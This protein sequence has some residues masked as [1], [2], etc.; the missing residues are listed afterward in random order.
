MQTDIY[1]TQCANDNKQKNKVK[2]SDKEGQHNHN[3]YKLH[4]FLRK[5]QNA[6]STQWQHLFI[7]YEYEDYDI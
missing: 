5:P 4:I 6:H 7:L 3:Y 2:D 1:H